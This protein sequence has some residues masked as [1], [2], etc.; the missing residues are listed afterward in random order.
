MSNRPAGRLR[1]TGDGAQKRRNRTSTTHP[2]PRPNG[3]YVY[4]IVPTVTGVRG[5][6]RSDRFAQGWARRITQ[7]L[8]VS[9][10]LSVRGSGV[11]R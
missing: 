2:R 7:S 10:G 6:D 1:D 4:G 9:A 5:A 8:A 3:V 11:V